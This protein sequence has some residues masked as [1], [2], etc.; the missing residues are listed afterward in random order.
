[1]WITIIAGAAILAILAWLAISVSGIIFQRPRDIS[2]LFGD[3]NT[4]SEKSE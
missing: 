3:K 2:N 1:M 4:A